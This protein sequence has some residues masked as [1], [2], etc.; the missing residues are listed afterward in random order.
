MKIQ[1]LIILAIII[2]VVNNPITGQRVAKFSDIPAHK[3]TKIRKL[4]TEIDDV[5]S[6]VTKWMKLKLGETIN[7]EQISNVKALATQ[8]FLTDKSETL[9]F[10][11]LWYVIATAYRESMLTAIE[12][13]KSKH[14]GGY[15][16]DI[17]NRYFYTDF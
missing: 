12:E 4:A 10:E 14:Y 15:L 16:W 1:N 13:I 9:R 7:E 3:L 5:V 17:Q 8:Y 11:R 2:M 6:N